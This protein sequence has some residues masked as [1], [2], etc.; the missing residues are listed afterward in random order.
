MRDGMRD[1]LPP[2]VRAKLDELRRDY[3]NLVSTY[4]PDTVPRWTRAWFFIRAYK[5]DAIVTAPF[6]YGLIIPIVLLDAFMTVYQHICFR[7]Y[8]VPLVRRGDFVVMDRAKL[9]YLTP[10][11]KIN[12]VY[13]EYA[14]GV[15]GYAQ[16]VAGRTEHFWCPIRHAKQPRVVH[17]HYAQFIGYGDDADFKGKFMA[18]REACRA[19][20]DPCGEK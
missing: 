11:Q 9:A 14:N 19:C 13:C 20:K 8:R 18:Q 3:E 15:L 6:I 4:P 17:Q 12:C 16:E 5:I 10:L 1:K 7:V 2:K